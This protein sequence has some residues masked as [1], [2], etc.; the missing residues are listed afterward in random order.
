VTAHFVIAEQ[1]IAT[2]QPT[3]A[4]SLLEFAVR[5]HSR[6]VYRIAYS[7]LR[8]PADAEDA[9]QEVFLRVLRYG[10]KAARIKDWKAWLPVS[11]GA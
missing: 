7:V 6:L 11:P 9:V 4:E 3:K 10:N 5:E 2:A 1:A 8:D